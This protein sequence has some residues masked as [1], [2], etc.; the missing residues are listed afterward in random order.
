MFKVIATL[1]LISSSCHSVRL[2]KKQRNELRRQIRDDIIDSAGQKYSSETNNFRQTF[3]AKLERDGVPR[4]VP[5][6]MLNHFSQ[7]TTI[8]FLKQTPLF[9]YGCWCFFGNMAA[10]IG[11]GIPVDSFDNLCKN[12]MQCYR[13]ASKDALS[14]STRCDPW[15]TDFEVD[16]SK[17]VL[18]WS[19]VTQSCSPNN[20][21]PCEYRTCACTIH[22][23]SELWDLIFN[24]DVNFDL[25]YKHDNGFDFSG[26]CAKTGG[27][28]GD[29]PGSEKQCCGVYPT[30][31][32]YIVHESRQCCQNSGVYNPLFQECCGDGQ[33]VKIGEG[34]C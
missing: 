10:S 19:N 11:H 1:Y 23:V 22:L 4:D 17:S 20:D 8:G 29:G 9:G 30:R 34:T 28:G 13:C 27:E 15:I 2:S 7:R 26:Q 25:A 33:V 6:W 14:E 3:A 16:T 31:S 32:I 5:E 21:V 24:P 18:I 12:F